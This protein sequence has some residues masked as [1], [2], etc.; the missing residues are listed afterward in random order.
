MRITDLLAEINIE[1]QKLVIINADSK[2]DNNRDNINSTLRRIRSMSGAL[3]NSSSKFNDA[4]SFFEKR[5]LKKDLHKLLNIMQNGRADDKWRVFEASNQLSRLC[6]KYGI[7][8]EYEVQDK[9]DVDRILKENQERFN[10]GLEDRI[11]KAYT[12]AKEKREKYGI[13][14]D[15]PATTIDVNEIKEAAERTQRI[16]FVMAKKKADRDSRSINSVENA[17][18]ESVMQRKIK[19]LLQDLDD[20]QDHESEDTISIRYEYQNNTYYMDGE[21]VL[22]RP[23]RLTTAKQK[24]EY[25]KS[26]LKNQSEFGYLFDTFIPDE[27]KALKNCDPYI[28]E[29]LLEKDV[30]LARDY[31]KQL[32]GIQYKKAS[33]HAFK[34]TYDV[35]G[36][37]SGRGGYLSSKERRSIRKTAK[38]QKNVGKVLEDKRKLPW[39]A[40]I[41]FVGALALAGIAGLTGLNSSSNENRDSLPGNSYT[42]TLAPGTTTD[43]ENETA[44]TETTTI[45]TTREAATT[46]TNIEDKVIFDSKN[47]SNSKESMVSE[48]NEN[49][50]KEEKVV[51]NV[52][53][54]IYV[55]DGLKYT[56]DCLGGGNSNRIGAV[57]WRPATEYNVERVAFV[58]DGKVLKI[59]N[60]GDMDI[61]QALNDIADENGISAEDI[62]TSVLLSLV[63]GSCDTGW[64]NI[65][66]NEMQQSLSKQTENQSNTISHVDFDFDR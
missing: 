64:A 45:T 43:L 53:D 16:D 4:L 1:V 14:E 31:I 6:S 18:Y 46:T 21:P 55:Q 65:S 22:K 35:R 27:R 34:V 66:L 19:E 33:P 44:T 39:Y 58:H 48:N 37:E 60:R 50:E 61:E 28:V 15:A 29:L 38:Q 23:E 56:A 49:D 51:V 12:A 59:M 11:G 30:R 13:R 26:K 36:L 57:S 20:D 62:N 52:G 10:P 24:E 54:K 25:I 3:M 9:F 42:D 63:P 5:E 40:A 2:N 17:R 32:T 41:P 7:D 47:N 8:Y